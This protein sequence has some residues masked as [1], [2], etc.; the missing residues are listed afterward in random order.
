MRHR[1]SSRHINE[2]MHSS[3]HDED[4]VQCTMAIRVYVPPWSAEIRKKFGKS[5]LATHM[6]DITRTCQGVRPRGSAPE[7]I[8]V[9]D[10]LNLAQKQNFQPIVDLGAEIANFRH[11]SR[12]PGL[13]F[14]E[15]RGDTPV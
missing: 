7:A 6:S 15:I 11:L 12:M 5:P 14:G 1:T 2:S 9:V 3:S 4:R 8:V 13:R 10:E